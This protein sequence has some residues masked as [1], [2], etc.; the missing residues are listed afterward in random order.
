MKLKS[1]A[2][3]KEEYPIDALPNTDIS[4]ASLSIQTAA[5]AA[6]PDTWMLIQPRDKLPPA[7]KLTLYLEAGLVRS[8]DWDLI[9]TSVKHNSS[10]L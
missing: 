9:A 1:G 2:I 5:K 8:F 6:K 10:L 4:K 7:T 3:F